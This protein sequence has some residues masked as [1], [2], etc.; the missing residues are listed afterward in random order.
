LWAAL[1]DLVPVLGAVIGALP[2]AILAT[3]S[4]PATGVFVLAFFLLYEV[5]EGLILQRRLES[6]TVHVGPFLTLVTGSIGLELY[7]IGGALFAFFATTVAVGV[8]EAWR[9]AVGAD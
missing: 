1:W 5:A 3:A 2:V 6:F 8:F 9:E 4:S 7:G